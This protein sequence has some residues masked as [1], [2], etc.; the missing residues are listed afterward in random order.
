MIGSVISPKRA[1]ISCGDPSLHAE[2][3]CSNAVR[4]CPFKSRTLSRTK[5]ILR[6]FA[7]VDS[8][9]QK[10][11]GKRRRLKHNDFYDLQKSG[12]LC[13]RSHAPEDSPYLR[14]L[15]CDIRLFNRKY[16]NYSSYK[17]DQDD[18]QEIYSLSYSEHGRSG[19]IAFSVYA[20]CDKSR[21]RWV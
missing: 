1:N 11:D 9:L 19:H 2:D 3:F 13:L 18:E 10:T 16:F 21:I 4:N 5:D 15:H 17:K 7:L 6:K 14:V 12:V 8:S 20:S